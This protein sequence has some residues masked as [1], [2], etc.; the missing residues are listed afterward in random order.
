[1]TPY[2]S[3]AQLV[4]ELGELEK[5][6]AVVQEQ[7]AGEAMGRAVGVCKVMMLCAPAD[8]RNSDCKSSVR[9]DRLTE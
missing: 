7:E 2:A 6:R 3:P 4:I 1:M 5:A 9:F 8:A